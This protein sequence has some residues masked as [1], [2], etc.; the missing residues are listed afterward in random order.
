MPDPIPLTKLARRPRRNR[1]HA[2]WRARL[3]TWLRRLADLVN[4]L[5]DFDA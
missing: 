5:E 1:R 2:G 3:A 4:P